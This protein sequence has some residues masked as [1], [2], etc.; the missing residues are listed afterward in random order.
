MPSSRGSSWP[1]DGI[2]FSYVSCWRKQWQPT[3]RRQWHPTPGLLPGK[4]HGWR[5]LVGCSPRGRKESDT[6]ERLHF[7]LFPVLASRFFI[8]NATWGWCRGGH[9]SVHRLCQV[10]REAQEVTTMK[11]KIRVYLYVVEKDRGYKE[12]MQK[13][14]SRGCK[15]SFSW[16]KW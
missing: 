5:S 14:V 10:D 7:H 2:R 9:Y 4:S 3:W 12:C 1:G 8:T 6:T 11:G 15:I 16:A 13:Q